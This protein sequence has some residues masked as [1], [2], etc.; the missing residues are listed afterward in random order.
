MCYCI[1]V[2]YL[3]VQRAGKPGHLLQYTVI[4]Y[5]TSKYEIDYPRVHVL[6]DV[7]LFLGGHCSLESSLGQMSRF[8]RR[9]IHLFQVFSTVMSKPPLI[10]I[11]LLATMG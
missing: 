6:Q 2:Y 9:G 7:Y 1:T 5:I 3:A 10:I 11:H 8:V 4:R